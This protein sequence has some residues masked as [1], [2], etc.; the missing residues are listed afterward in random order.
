MDE[1]RLLQEEF[2]KA[3]AE[4]ITQKISEENCIE[5]ISRLRQLNI[6][7]LHHTRDGREYFT[8]KNLQREIEDEIELS[9]GR[10]NI[11][12]LV[13]LL[14]V[15]FW[16][17]EKAI[18]DICE[19]ND[20]YSFLEGQIISDIYLNNL[21]ISW[22]EQLFAL[23]RLDLLSI[24]S[25]AQIPLNFAKQ[26]INQRL[27]KNIF[28]IISENTIYTQIYIEFCEKKIF[29]KLMGC[30]TPLSLSKACKAMNMDNFVF[31]K[32]VE[33]IVNSSKLPG[34]IVGS[35]GS[36]TYIPDIFNKIGEKLIEKRIVEA[37]RID[38][39]YL[40]KFG[41]SFSDFKD[42]HIID[43]VGY[44][45]IKLDEHFLTIVDLLE[46]QQYV[47][48]AQVFGQNITHHQGEKLI[49]L[50]DSSLKDVTLL[51]DIIFSSQ[52]LNLAKVEFEGFI[53]EKALSL[54]ES[55][56][57]YKSVDSNW[58]QLMDLIVYHGLLFDKIYD[59]D[60]KEQL[61][62]YC[63]KS[64]QN[65]Y[66]NVIKSHH[67]SVEKILAE[68]VNKWKENTTA[69]MME[70]LIAYDKMKSIEDL[71]QYCFKLAQRVVGIISDLL[72]APARF[73]RKGELP[74][75]FEIDHSYSSNEI[76][77]SLSYIDDV[78]MNL[79]GLFRLS[80]GYPFERIETHEVEHQNKK[81]KK[82]KS[83][84]ALKRS[85]IEKI[86]YKE[87]YLDEFYEKL[88]IF[89]EENSQTFFLPSLSQK[90]LVAF[91][92]DKLCQYYTI[93][94]NCN[95][96]RQRFHLIVLILF[97]EP[98]Y[99]QL[100]PKCIPILINEMCETRNNMKFTGFIQELQNEVKHSIKNKEENNDQKILEHLVDFE[101]EYLDNLF[102]N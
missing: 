2:Y 78:K 5:I 37:G 38:E 23:G 77:S 71:R 57:Q 53:D 26:I 25:N 80:Q 58:P 39:S 63:L 95:D 32:S 40:L 21:C 13:S 42:L 43:T 100:P 69:A 14:N 31:S 49:S 94:K 96:P 56:P 66:E 81:G 18:N 48:V 47:S 8:Y 59:D 102:V 51:G 35:F 70:F 72:A 16:L 68:S 20:C 1:L 90:N 41:K 50:W 19:E 60:V 17:I 83:K 75:V 33:N 101:K 92:K 6:I 91:S 84:K 54:V 99:V 3:Q 36:G 11:I 73:E 34:K 67:V 28:G 10:L 79:E 65:Y 82:N 7:E 52:C 30:I 4:V 89:F 29:G 98:L 44:S 9:G 93:L 22:N 97:S 55:N 46:S 74:T 45:P 87:E 27:N 24:S 61:Y 86:E 88:L 76:L 15:D 85:T 62:E 64:C 12:D